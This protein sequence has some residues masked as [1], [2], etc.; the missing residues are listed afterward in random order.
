MV[1]H[2]RINI[3]PAIAKELQKNI[4]NAKNKSIEKINKQLEKFAAIVKKQANGLLD[5]YRET[6][7]WLKINLVDDIEKVEKL[8]KLFSTIEIEFND[9]YKTWTSI[10][11]EK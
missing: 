7:E 1:E 8:T 10:K 3:I 2:K 6:N 9:V 11:G 5:S 4:N